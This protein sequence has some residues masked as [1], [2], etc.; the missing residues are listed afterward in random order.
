MAL[1]D[2]DARPDE[3]APAVRPSVRNPSRPAAGPHTR[4]VVP[5]TRTA[6]PNTDPAYWET[7][8][9]LALENDTE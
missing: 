7:L 6:S 5:T 1:H 4:S 8:M 2:V 9:L 3:R